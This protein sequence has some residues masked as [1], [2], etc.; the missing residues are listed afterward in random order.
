MYNKRYS[1][2]GTII[3]IIYL[4]PNTFPKTYHIFLDF[5][6]VEHAHIGIYLTRTHYTI[7]IVIQCQMIMTMI[8]IK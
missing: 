2:D 8:I 6:N 1:K 4:A 5:P 7:W 3:L